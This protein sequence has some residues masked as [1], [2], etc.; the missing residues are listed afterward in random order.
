[1]ITEYI[2]LNTRTQ[3]TC[4]Y[5]FEKI[6]VS[7]ILSIKVTG[8]SIN[9]TASKARPQNLRAG[10]S[11]P[12]P[13]LVCLHI[14]EGLKGCRGT[15]ELTTDWTTRD[16]WHWI[17]TRGTSQTRWTVKATH[18][19]RPWRYWWDSKPQPKRQTCPQGPHKES[20]RDR[21]RRIRMS[22]VPK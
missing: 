12:N 15:L 13:Q 7:R 17:Q 8:I 6:Y 5:F 22:W 4:K 1:M 16:Q 3:S 10:V 9:V 18:L 19:R 14:P 2:I 11:R 21:N 20:E